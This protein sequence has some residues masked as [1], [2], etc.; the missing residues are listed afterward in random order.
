MDIRSFYPSINPV[1]A[2]EIARMMWSESS[3]D[4]GEINVDELA[5]Y[6]GKFTPSDILESS[7]MRDF[8]YNKKVVK[9]TR[10]KWTK[11]QF[12]AEERAKKK[13]NKKK[14]KDP[15]ENWEKP[16]RNPSK[17]EIKSLLGIA[18]QTLILAV[19]T[20]HIYQFKGKARLQAMGGPTGLDLTGELA[21]LIMIW[22]DRTF[23]K[24]MAD[25]SIE[26]D[27]YKRFKDD[28]N[29]IMDAISPGV[30]YNKKFDELIYPTDWFK[31]N[32]EEQK[33]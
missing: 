23:L 4:P 8:V 12:E 31:L 3:L 14:V 18:L 10:K 29:L 13:K 6:I 2:A 24:L 5:F 17:L 32:Y 28:I 1:R 21:D 20:G 19:M 33:S 30:Q 11:K 26:I 27:L 7:G 9:K 16:V 25:M 22:W 15:K